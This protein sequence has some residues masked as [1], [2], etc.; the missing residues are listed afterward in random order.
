[1]EEEKQ[2]SGDRREE[3]VRKKG[4]EVEE[5]EGVGE[6]GRRGRVIE[7]GLQKSRNVFPF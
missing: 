7:S 4:G 6:G 2:D 5:V 1:M 3:R